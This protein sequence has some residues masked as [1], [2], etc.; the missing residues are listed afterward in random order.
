MNEIKYKEESREIGNLLSTNNSAWLSL[1]HH[2]LSPPK[3]QTSRCQMSWFLKIS[4]YAFDLICLQLQSPQ[5]LHTTKIFK[6]KKYFLNSRRH[7]WTP[8]IQI[9]EIASDNH[10]S[11]QIE[12]FPF[13]ISDNLTFWCE[14]NICKCVN[15]RESGA[16]R[17]DCAVVTEDGG[18]GEFQASLAFNIAHQVLIDVSLPRH[19]CSAK[20]FSKLIHT[21][22][23]EIS[24]R[25]I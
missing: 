21:L 11:E 3:E 2:I 16:L 4:Q 8:N 12:H 10:E 18:G 14:S 24:D 6:R 17:P 13:I 23:S 5:T 25:Y 9:E 19:Y 7:N 1:N 22:L 15:L 20:F